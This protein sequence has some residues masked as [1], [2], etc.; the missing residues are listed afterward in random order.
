[1]LRHGA[2]ALPGIASIPGSMLAHDRA[3]DR[4][5]IP[6]RPIR[7]TG[8]GSDTDSLRR[9]YLDLLKLCLCDRS[10]SAIPTDRELQLTDELTALRARVA[11]VEARLA[12]PSLAGAAA[13]ARQRAEAITSAIIRR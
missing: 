2:D 5:P 4:P 10:R 9:A 11:E 8:P 3:A 1:M 6:P 13:W 7:T 12:R